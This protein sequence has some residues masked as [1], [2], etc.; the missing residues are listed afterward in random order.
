M[1]IPIKH[2]HQPHEKSSL[3]FYHK[4]NGFHGA[5]PTKFKTIFMAKSSLRFKLWFSWGKTYKIQNYFYG[6]ILPEV[7]IMVFM[8]QNLQ[9]S[10]LFLWQN[11]PQ[12]SK[13]FFGQYLT[14]SDWTTHELGISKT[15]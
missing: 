12:S 4:F 13:I 9:N 15:D 14:L 1:Q 5:K 7:Q 10:K 11:P 3:T 8:G 6:K 2:R